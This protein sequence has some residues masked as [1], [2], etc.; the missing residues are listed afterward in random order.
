MEAIAEGKYVDFVHL[1]KDDPDKTE[2]LEVKQN[3]LTFYLPA[4]KPP[5]KVESLEVWQKSFMV[6]H[7]AF[8]TFFPEKAQELL[9]YRVHIEGLAAVFDWS[10]V[11]AYDKHFHRVQAAKPYRP[12]G[13]TNQV[14]K[15]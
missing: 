12:W 10:R 2:N 15:D 14:A 3:N 1:L 4:S 11:Y 13:L 9:E 5:T 7:S 6:F 8:Q